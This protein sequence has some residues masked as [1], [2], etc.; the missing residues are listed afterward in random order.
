MERTSPRERA[1]RLRVLATIGLMSIAKPALVATHM[2]PAFPGEPKAEQ[3]LQDLD[4]DQSEQK[5]TS[6]KSKLG[7]GIE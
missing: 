3:A 6:L 1:E 5:K 7:L 4:I 2:Q